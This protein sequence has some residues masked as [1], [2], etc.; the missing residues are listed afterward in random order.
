MKIDSGKLKI[1]SAKLK[2]EQEEEESIELKRDIAENTDT[3]QLLRT[4]I[5][6]IKAHVFVK[7]TERR[8]ILSNLA[9]AQS[10]GKE[11][12][13]EVIGLRDED[14][15]HP[16][17]RVAQY[18]KNDLHVLETGASLYNLPSIFY[19]SKG[20]VSKRL[21]SKIPY[22]S[23][24][25]DIIGLIGVNR[26]VLTDEIA[27][28]EREHFFDLT[29]DLFC[30]T[31][32]KGFFRHMNA[33]AWM[34]ALGYTMADMMA[35]SSLAFIHPDDKQ[36][37]LK[38]Y[39]DMIATRKRTLFESRVRCKD[40]TYI[41]LR[42]NAVYDGQT[43]SIY[44]IARDVTWRKEIE[45]EWSQQQL[46]LEQMVAE[47]TAELQAANAQLKQEIAERQL[48]EEA[49]R[50][51][52]T[53]LEEKATDLEA[54]NQEL[55]QYTY[56]VS[57]DIKAPLRAIHNYAE[58]LSEDLAGTLDEEQEEYLSGLTESVQDA[59]ELVDDLLTLSRIGRNE[60]R[61][62]PVHLGNLLHELIGT[63]NFA[64]FSE[65][66][67]DSDV[68]ID[69]TSTWPLFESQPFL[70]RQIFQNL[71]QNSL[72]FNISATKQVAIGWRLLES[73]DI[74]IFVRDNGIGIDAKYHTKI[75]GIFQRLHTHDEYEGTGIG[76][77]IVQ[78]ATEKLHGKIRVESASGKGSTFFI[79][80][81]GVIS[82]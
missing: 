67:N 35:E 19:N 9:H 38:Q 69:I 71:I 33:A 28:R 20:E 2:V 5:D 56:V 47:R 43:D 41:W 36:E 62:E 64:N 68:D 63:L 1:D 29:L 32:I 7:D 59:Q 6:M 65:N 45:S 8:F 52:H 66:G 75:F 53:E 25:G 12:P 40:G 78:K 11:S 17:E 73:N 57:H 31:D 48:T 14:F 39:Q 18:K 15:P 82:A 42:W 16:S 61:P 74:E 60:S 58:F 23:D 37:A 3:V 22:Y 4:V 46:Q 27:V 13:S 24:D 26:Q 30:I 21:V 77:A 34:E 49:L 44:A 10:L 72:K 70:L 81:P 76:L 54:A 80:L 50:M 51:A 79:T 55:A